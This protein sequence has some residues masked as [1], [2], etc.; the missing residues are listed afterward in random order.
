MQ[1]QPDFLDIYRSMTTAAAEMLKVALR[2]TGQ[3]SEQQLQW[4]RVALEQNDRFMNRLREVS[5]INDLF[6]AQSQFASSQ[7][8]QGI[9]AWWRSFRILQDSQLA[10]M[11]RME[12]EVGQLRRQ[13]EEPLIK[14]SAGGAVLS[15]GRLPLPPSPVPSDARLRKSVWALP[16]DIQFKRP[17]GALHRRR[18]L[19]ASKRCPSGRFAS[20]GSLTTMT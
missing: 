11:S 17:P 15:D 5:D 4:A 12:T 2:N 3:L 6:L 9:E 19:C 16:W 13:R 10:A 8:T 18:V 14:Q 20:T 1:A 7:L